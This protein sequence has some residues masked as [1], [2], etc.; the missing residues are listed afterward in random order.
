MNEAGGGGDTEPAAKTRLFDRFHGEWLEIFSAILLAL[1]TVASAWSAYQ[2]ARWHSEESLLFNLATAARVHAAEA[3]DLADAELDI[4][5]EMFLDYR[6]AW[7]AGDEAALLDFETNLF[8]DEMEVAMEAWKATDPYNNPEA[9]STPFEMPDY[10]NANREMSR[11]LE[12]E[13]QEKL[14]EAKDAIRISDFYVMLTVLFASVLFFAGICTK[15]K[16]PWVRVAVLSMGGL[17]FAATLIITI[18]RP[19]K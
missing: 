2:A 13:A 6:D 17:L 18:T 14:D 5:V 3:A 12:A 4:D 9:P 1:A 10:V 7:R 15:F 16:A 19:I 8:R 11:D